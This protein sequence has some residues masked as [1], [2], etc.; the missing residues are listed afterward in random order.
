MLS[1]YVGFL[2]ATREIDDNVQ[3]PKDDLERDGRVTIA[4]CC[5]SHSSGRRQM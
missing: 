1:R 3:H 5:N 2:L 4:G